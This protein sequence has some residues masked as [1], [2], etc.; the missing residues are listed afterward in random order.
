MGLAESLI[1]SG[2]K[3]EVDA[4]IDTLKDMLETQVTP[5]SA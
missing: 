4:N 1:A 2:L 3:R 5:I